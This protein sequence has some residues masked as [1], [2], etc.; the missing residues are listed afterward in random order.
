MSRYEATPRLNSDTVERLTPLPCGAVSGPPDPEQPA[1]R[2]ASATA[3]RAA[4]VGRLRLDC[5]PRKSGFVRGCVESG[6]VACRS[7]IACPLDVVASPFGHAISGRNFAALWPRASPGGVAIRTG[8][9]DSV[10]IRVT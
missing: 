6:A 3:K 2:H 8:F 4:Q 9:R 1:A 7:N 10:A 5:S